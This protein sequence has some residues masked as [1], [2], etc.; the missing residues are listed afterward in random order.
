MIDVWDKIYMHI[1]RRPWREIDQVI[2]KSDYTFHDKTQLWTAVSS[3]FFAHGKDITDHGNQ[4]LVDAEAARR[5]RC[6]P[7]KQARQE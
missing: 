4:A 7:R 2:E 1:R 5:L 3:V 6:P